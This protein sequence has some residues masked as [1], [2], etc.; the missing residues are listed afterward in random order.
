MIVFGG[1]ADGSDAGGRYDPR[2]DCWSPLPEDG[3]PPGRKGATAV[4]TGREMIVWGGEED[5]EGIGAQGD[6]GQQSA[7]ITHDPA[8]RCR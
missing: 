6:G 7:G 3:A 5:T 4:W 2:N 8:P 1:E